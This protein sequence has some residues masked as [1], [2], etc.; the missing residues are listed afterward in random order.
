[1]SAQPKRKS[2]RTRKTSY[3]DPERHP[4]PL[5]STVWVDPKQRFIDGLPK[6]SMARKTT[7][8]YETGLLGEEWDVEGYVTDVWREDS[9]TRVYVI[10]VRRPNSTNM[11]GW[12]L[13][14]PPNDPK[15]LVELVRA[16]THPH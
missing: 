1:M 6:A 7:E 8:K 15:D 13:D 14:F 4:S 12:V 10:G 2:G 9:T 5:P 11:G 16:Q 3:E